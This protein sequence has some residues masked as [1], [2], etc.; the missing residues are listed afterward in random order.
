MNIISVFTNSKLSITK[1]SQ[2]IQISKNVNTV[3]IFQLP[4]VKNN[5]CCVK[6][7]PSNLVCCHWQQSEAGGSGKHT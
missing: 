7:G 4:I 2:L 6:D 1:V 3:T 5:L